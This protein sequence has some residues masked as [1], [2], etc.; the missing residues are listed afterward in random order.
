MPTPSAASTIRVPR[1]IVRL[2]HLALR[3]PDLP[4]AV[5]FYT[6][7][8]RLAVA[9][10]A[11]GRVY[12]RGQFEHHCLELHAADRADVLH[13]GWETDSDEATAALRAWVESRGVPVR[14]APA[15]PGR[16]GAA[17]QFQ[18]SLGMWNEVYRAT[19][20]LPVLVPA[21][22]APRLRLAHVTRMS[23]SPDDDLAFF[24][25]LGFRVSDWVPGVQAFLR[26]AAEHHA[27]G[28]L[29]YDRPLLHHHAY[30]VGDW[31]SIKA[32]MDWLAA[33]GWPVEVGPVR[34]A[35]GNNIAV[36]VRDPHGVRVEFFCEMETIADDEDH[37]ARRQPVLFDL[38]R[39]SPPP[40][41]FRE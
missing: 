35:A 24:R 12:L 20:R 33:Q 26:C 14:A 40:P 8:V 29:K 37:D 2:G 4:R 34:H 38:W 10:E 18:D 6:R 9:E 41:G 28:F 25:A 17:F 15:E 31:T 7:V 3:V 11:E 19:A 16:L 5:D 32:V 39:Q 22:P 30:D 1:R 27:V 13:L 23:P 21:G 36:Y